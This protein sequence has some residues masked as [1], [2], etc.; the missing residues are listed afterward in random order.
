MK[1]KNGK[2]YDN[3]CFW[4]GEDGFIYMQTSTGIITLTLHQAKEL[5]I[6]EKLAIECGKKKTL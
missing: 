1:Y 6:L 2:F 5:G 3:I 4:Q